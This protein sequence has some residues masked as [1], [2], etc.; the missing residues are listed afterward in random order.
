LHIEAV[1]GG[2]DGI[3]IGGLPKIGKGETSERAGLI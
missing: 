1:Q 3:C 2:N